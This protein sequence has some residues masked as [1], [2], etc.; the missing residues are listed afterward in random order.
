M[1]NEVDK[2]LSKKYCRRFGQIA[3]EHGFVSS[4]EVKKALSEQVDDDLASRPHRL[5]GRILMDKGLMSPQ[6]IDSVMND[7][8][9]NE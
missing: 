5:L 1:G 2:E 6:Q 7:L 9:K 4:E 8:F 3:V